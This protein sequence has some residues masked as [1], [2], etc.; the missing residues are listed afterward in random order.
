MKKMLFATI[1][2]GAAVAAN[3]PAVYAADDF[4]KGREIKMIVGYSAGG[5][6]DFYAR[7]VA[8]YFSRHIPGNP[9]IVV[10]NMPGASSVKAANYLYN[11]ASKDGTVLGALGSTLVLNK[12]LGRP[13]KYDPAK[14]V[15]I[16]RIDSGD[17]VGLAWHDSGVA[18]IDDAKKKQVAMAGGSRMGPAVMVPA[19]LNNLL[20]T[21]FKIIQ[22]YRGSAKMVAAMER[23]EAAGT[24]T[25]GLAALLNNKA[26][27][28]RENKVNIL[29]IMALDRNPAIPNVPTLIELG[30]TDEQKAVL[31]LLTSRSVIGRNFTAP[32]GIPAERAALLR[33]AFD[34]LAS[35]AQF[36]EY[37]KSKQINI[38]PM[39]GE[40][41]EA[42]VNKVTDV[43]PAVIERAKKATT[44]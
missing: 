31:R 4:Y 25:Y 7:L 12:M 1:G 22:G 11:A 14:F 37:T 2:L 40:K 15:W 44:P 36:R 19:A 5:G 41:L 23:G 32:P 26:H 43:S 42:F 28:L 39:S 16:G 21:K 17:A 8:Q 29:F 24:A 20:G 34:E 35:D 18:S 9:R 13:A 38:D 30:K 6:F 33:K 10:Q 3:L 27:W